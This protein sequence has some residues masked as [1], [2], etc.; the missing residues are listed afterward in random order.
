MDRKQHWGRATGPQRQ[1]G[2]ATAILPAVMPAIIAITLAACGGGGGGGGGGGPVVKKQFVEVKDTVND[3]PANMIVGI[4][5]EPSYALGLVNA[6]PSGGSGGYRGKGVTVAVID[7]E[8]DDGHPDLRDAFARDGNGNAIGRNVAEGHDDTRPVAQRLRKPRSDIT[9]SASAEEMREAEKHIDT[10]FGKSISHGT[11][12]AGIIAARDNGFGVIGVAPEAKLL[13]VTL[14]RDRDSIQYNRYGL[15]DL[16]ES[17][18]PDWNRK[19]AAS[20]NYAA[21]RNVFV[22]NNSWGYPWFPHEISSIDDKASYPYYFRLPNFFLKPDLVARVNQHRQIF[23]AA[24]IAALERA[25]DGRDGAAIVFSAGNDGWNSETGRHKIFSKSLFNLDRSRRSWTDYRNDKFE[26]IKTVARPITLRDFGNQIVDVPANIPGLESS[27]FL[28]NPKLWGAWLAVVAI[29]KKR[30]ITSWSNGCGIAKDYCLAAPGE[31]VRSTFARGD[32]EDVANQS[33]DGSIGDIDKA[34]GDGYGTYSGTSMAAPIVSGA[35]AVLKSKDPQ[36]TARQAVKA[37]L[38]T[39]TE[40]KESGRSGVTKPTGD[41]AIEGCVKTSDEGSG[42]TYEGG[43]TPSEVYGHGLVN[44]A[45]AL[46]PIGP[47]KAAAANAFGIAPTGDTRVAFSAAFGDAAPSAEHHFGGF[48]SLGRVYRY[49]APLQDRVMPGQRLAGVMAMA[50]PAAPVMMGRT[51]GVTTMLRRSHDAD[52][53][54]GAGGV[55]SYIGARSRTDLALVNRRTASALSP[56]ALLRRSD[57]VTP[58]WEALAPQAHDIIGAAWSAEGKRPLSW[59]PAGGRLCAGTADALG[60]SAA[61]GIAPAGAG[62]VDWRG[63]AASSR[64]GGFPA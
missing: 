35:L 55:V 48:D 9:E 10:T 38:C 59:Q 51:N 26:Y 56:A 40:I 20:V 11:H 2:L 43:W 49:K 21:T 61:A 27:Y 50:A 37:L 64:A 41:A 22:I 36:L 24:A 32:G 3:V 28:T 30:V 29:D 39:A 33:E 19:V 13:P 53:A 5:Q 42:L 14:F 23:D 63:M 34:T 62:A 8:F 58:V 46:Q 54:I 6:D 47:T 16:N 18:L 45:R 17:D 52:S 7:S 44:L 25:V 1:A 4:P 60:L 57:V 12:V 31:N 15:S